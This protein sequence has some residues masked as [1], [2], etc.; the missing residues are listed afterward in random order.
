[1]HENLDLRLQVRPSSKEQL[2]N[3]LIA[4]QPLWSATLPNRVVRLSVYA[5]QHTSTDGST[6]IASTAP[7]PPDLQP[8]LTGEL[9]TDLEGTFSSRINLDWE[10]LC[11]HPDT[12]SI[13]FGEHSSEPNIVVHAELLPAPIEFAMD[14][15]QTEPAP[16]KKIATHITIP[17][18]QA[19]TRLLSDIDDTIKVAG[20]LAG[21]RTVFR[22]VFTKNP[23][24][25]IIKGMAD[26]YRSLFTRGV[27]FHY[28]SNSPF[29][30][31]PIINEF[32]STA[33]LPEGKLIV[34]GNQS[35]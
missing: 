27:R 12:A 28:V 29:G 8:I 19:K 10:I 23:E 30:L 1:M 2:D 26:W 14:G 17:I 20:I 6:Q 24:E 35:F 7:L 25:L 33:R 3:R 21:A 15:S 34:V 32:L 5:P 18:T 4:S 13:A 11:T 9:Y 22:N 16:I 31:L